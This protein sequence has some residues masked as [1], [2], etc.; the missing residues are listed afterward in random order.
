MTGFFAQLRIQLEGTN[1][2]KILEERGRQLQGH[3]DLKEPQY[4]VFK[5]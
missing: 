5:S 1:V 2:V 3:H 4:V